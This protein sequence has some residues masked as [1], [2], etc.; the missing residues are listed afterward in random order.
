MPVR[1]L[2]PWRILGTSTGFPL[3]CRHAHVTRI[4][5]SLSLRPC[6]VPRLAPYLRCVDLCTIVLPRVLQARLCACCQKCFRTLLSG[7]ALMRSFSH[8]KI[9]LWPP[10]CSYVRMLRSSHCTLTLWRSSVVLRS[11]LIYLALRAACQDL[12][13]PILSHLG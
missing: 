8:I 12:L 4:S 11:E 3:L 6:L 5:C 7:C 1:V 9:A 13:A 10:C 2:L